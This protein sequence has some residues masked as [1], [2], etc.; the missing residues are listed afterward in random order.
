MENENNAA[1]C[2]HCHKSLVWISTAERWYIDRQI[3]ELD[4]RCDSCKREFRFTEG[5][6]RE[7]KDERKSVRDPV[8]EQLAIHEAE[9]NTARNCRCSNCGGPLD[10]WL[11]CEWCHERYSITNGVLVSKIAEIPHPKPKMSDYYALE[12]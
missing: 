9:I 12:R 5:K 2:F 4:F 8:A 10:E 1:E 11:T 6:L 3:Y 7:R